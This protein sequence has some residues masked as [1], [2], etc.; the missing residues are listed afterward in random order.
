MRT[1]LLATL[2]VLP[3]LVFA[4]AKLK[5]TG[6]VSDS[7]KSLALVTV[8]LFQQNKPAPLQMT[9]SKENGNFELIKPGA[10]NY[11]LSFTHTGFAEK[12]ISI[13]VA[14]SSG[15][16]QIDKVVLSPK[17]STLKE[18]VVKT[19]R[20]LVEQA[21]DKIIFNVED[22]PTSKTETAL[23]ILRSTPFVTVDGNDNIK[24]NGQTNFKVLLNGRETSM[25]ANNVRDALR[26]F[27]GA[28]ISKIEVITNPSAKYDA[29]GIGGLINIITKKKVVG[30]N[31]TI[32]SFQRTSDKLS[33]YNIN[34][35]AKVGKFGLSV[36]LSTGYS[37]PVSQHN[38]ST[39]IPFT[40]IAYTSR[41][42]DGNQLASAGWS[43]GNAEL[44]YDIDTLNTVTL[45]TNIDSWSSKTVSDQTITTDFSSYPSTVSNY[46]LNNK[47]NN[48]GVNVGSD[49]VRHYSKSKDREFSLRFLGEFGKNDSK[50]NSLQ[51]GGNSNRYLI[52]N[53]NAINDQYTLQADNIIPLT[54]T[55][56]LEAGVKAILRRA[57]SNFES[58]VTYD[59]SLP[60]KVNP[61]NTDFFKYTQDVFSVYSTYNFKLKKWGIRLGTR[62]EYT[63]VNGN[64]ISSGPK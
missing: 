13:S 29:E 34:A 22:D 36:L 23:D 1:Y 45:Y 50:L 58:L 15:N 63:N 64:F 4:Q 5:L 25:F 56:K 53:S 19:Q 7:S 40:P 55:S 46:H 27:P 9:L 32:S 61:A 41:T 26:G 31:G 2:C 43:F 52:N 62:V 47:S 17:D 60:Y 14:A 54:K 37:N 35:N 12:Q 6:T 49:Y 51:D 39:T 11:T 8:R 10:G 28:I 42:L 59:S 30:Y 20:P 57:N 38:T 3:G 33:D 24:V 18:V 48:P 44:N 21:D 16:M